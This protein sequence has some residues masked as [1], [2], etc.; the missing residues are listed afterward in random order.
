[1]MM[2]CMCMYAIS[3]CS[4]ASIPFFQLACLVSGL[5]VCCFQTLAMVSE[6]HG[7]F[8]PPENRPQTRCAR[9]QR[10]RWKTS[11]R[12]LSSAGLVDAV[13]ILCTDTPSTRGGAFGPLP[14]PFMCVCIY[15]KIGSDT[16]STMGVS[17][18]RSRIHVCSVCVCVY[19]YIYTYTYINTICIQC[20]PLPLGGGGSSSDSNP[21]LLRCPCSN[22]YLVVAVRTW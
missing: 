8:V 2:M 12:C 20:N 17:S 15:A 10:P 18:D 13:R 9:L 5:L 3:V 11:H 21:Y 19:I 16:P 1:M 4:I 22:L 6:E 14:H 7:L